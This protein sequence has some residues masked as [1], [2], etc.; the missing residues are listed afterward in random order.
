[1]DSILYEYLSESIGGLDQSVSQEE[2]AF[3]LSQIRFILLSGRKKRCDS[4]LLWTESMH[5]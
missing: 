3:G 4:G 1:M 2:R 5:F